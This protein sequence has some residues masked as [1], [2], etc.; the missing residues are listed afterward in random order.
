VS[1]ER[2]TNAENLFKNHGKLLCSVEG[3]R[4]FKVSMN[5]FMRG[6]G[7]AQVL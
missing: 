7:G 5:V 1:E 3:L 4:S 2:F 6:G